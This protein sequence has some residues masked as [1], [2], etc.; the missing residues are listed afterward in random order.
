MTFPDMMAAY[1]KATGQ[2]A[3]IDYTHPAG[4]SLA[5]IGYGK[6]LYG[7]VIPID[8]ASRKDVIEVLAHD[9]GHLIQSP[10]P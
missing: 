8:D 6:K 7:I 10:T 2:R 1:F 9:A 5:T 3:F 4:P